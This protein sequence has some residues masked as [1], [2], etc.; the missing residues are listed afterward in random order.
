M[1]GDGFSN[2]LYG[3]G[4]Y[5]YSVTVEGVEV[6]TGADFGFEI[7]HDLCADLGC[8]AEYEV[9]WGGAAGDTYNCAQDLIVT[10]NLDCNP[11][12]SDICPLICGDQCPDYP[13]DGI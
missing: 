8:S 3:D 11:L 6:L 9:S 12:V 2:A 13:A 7:Q 4:D 5:G 10:D 1:G